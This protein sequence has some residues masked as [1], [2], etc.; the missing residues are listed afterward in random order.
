MRAFALLLSLLTPLTLL[1][2]V[3]C[4]TSP[5]PASDGVDASGPQ[6]I[7]ATCD[8]SRAD[9]CLPT[10]DV[11]TGVTCDP[12]LRVCLE[13]ATDAGPPCNAGSAP[14]GSTADCDLGLTCGFPVTGGCSA[15]GTCIDPPLPCEND[16][17]S[18]ATAPPVC[19][20]NG[21]PD[22]LVVGGYATAPVASTVACID[23]GPVLDAGSLDAADA[24]G[25]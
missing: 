19:G 20:C 10:G 14:C 4:S 8:P 1:S 17:A 21:L 15:R 11:C 13:F 23:G 25:D 6:G 3:A 2:L 22:P 18:C 16:A 12:A 9:P 7:G 24:A 5:G